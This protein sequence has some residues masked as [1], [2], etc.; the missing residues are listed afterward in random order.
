LFPLESKYV[1][2]REAKARCFAGGKLEHR[3]GALSGRSAPR[4]QMRGDAD[5]A[6]LAVEENGVDHE[7]HE[8]RMNGAGRL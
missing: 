4:S 6:L 5:D 2:S 1:S 7:A 3:P 8:E